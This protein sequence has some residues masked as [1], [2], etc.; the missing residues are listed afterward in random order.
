MI[1]KNNQID[2]DIFDKII[3]QNCVINQNIRSKNTLS[4]T[5][6]L[7]SNRV[8]FSNILDVDTEQISK[9]KE[10]NTRLLNKGKSKESTRKNNDFMKEHSLLTKLQ[11]ANSSKPQTKIYPISIDNITGDFSDWSQDT[12]RILSAQYSAITEN[13]MNENN[14]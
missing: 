3:S 12:G 13:K 10:G 9:R 14:K 1:S 4:E 8:G 6:K 7:W 11:E 5:R 2:F